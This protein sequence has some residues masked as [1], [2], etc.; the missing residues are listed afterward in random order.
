[1]FKNDYSSNHTDCMEFPDSLSPFVSVIKAQL[2][3]TVEYTDCVSTE[4]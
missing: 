4:T 2:A 1:M 3:E